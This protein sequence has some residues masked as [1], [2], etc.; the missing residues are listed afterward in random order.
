MAN[1]GVWVTVAETKGSA[2]R[3]AGA[4]MWV[5]ADH[6]LGTIGGGALEYQAILEART[7][8]ADGAQEGFSESYA[9]GPALDQCC[10]GR[11]E[12]N[13]EKLDEAAAEARLAS[14]G[15]HR[16]YMFGAGHV[17]RAVARALA[18]LDYNVVWVDARAD[19]FPAETAPHIRAE[20]TDDPVAIVQGAE[21]GSHFLIFTHSHPLDYDLTA[22]VLARGD[23]AYCGLIGSRTKRARFENRM[24]RERV[25]TEDDLPN[26][27]CPIGLPDIKGKEPSVIAAS[28]VAQLLMLRP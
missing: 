23:A 27:T 16:L 1:P 22:A 2:P 28:V 19:E 6:I 21:P 15:R 5:G 7:L 4:A 8:L 13:F 20:V 18:P 3:E 25:I 11:V 26:L 10:G 9:L 17:G 14:R 24:L 12:L